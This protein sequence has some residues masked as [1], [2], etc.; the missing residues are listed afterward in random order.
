VTPQSLPILQTQVL[1]APSS[2][3]CPENAEKASEADGWCEYTSL[4]SELRQPV[5][6]PYAVVFSNRVLYV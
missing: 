4:T 3:L 5:P 2:S 1:S 6:R